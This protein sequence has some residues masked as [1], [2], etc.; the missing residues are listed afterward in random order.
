MVTDM[1][2][3]AYCYWCQ[4]L[5]NI[6]C[7]VLFFNNRHSL[8]EDLIVILKH[9]NQIGLKFKIISTNELQD[10]HIQCPKII[11]L[12]ISLSHNLSGSD[13]SGDQW[14]L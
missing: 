2:W 11:L 5:N 3:E 6:N 4:P 10:L 9:K 7:F 14:S 1:Y 8:K 13:V 12:N